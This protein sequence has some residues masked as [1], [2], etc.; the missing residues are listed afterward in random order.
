MGKANQ[1]KPGAAVAA[2]DKRQNLTA[3]TD[4]A[5]AKQNPGRPQGAARVLKKNQVPPG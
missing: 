2:V 1:V 4:S 3:A 5:A